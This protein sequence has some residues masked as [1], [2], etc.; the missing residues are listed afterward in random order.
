[1]LTLL[2]VVNVPGPGTYPVQPMYVRELACY[3]V[4]MLHDPRREPDAGDRRAGAHSRS[5][6]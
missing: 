5:T 6:G 3:V 1:M 4:A 2:P